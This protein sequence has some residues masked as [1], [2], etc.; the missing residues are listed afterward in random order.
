MIWKKYC[1]M[2][3]QLLYGFNFF[4]KTFMLQF[5]KGRKDKYFVFSLSYNCY[6]INYIQWRIAISRPDVL[7]KDNKE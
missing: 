7:P 4:S 6:D 1:D 2:R 5:R 3:I